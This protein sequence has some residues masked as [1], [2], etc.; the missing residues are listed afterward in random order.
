[1]RLQRPISPDAALRV[2]A[3]EVALFP[4]LRPASPRTDVD[5]FRFSVVV[6]GPQPAVLGL[7][8]G[9]FVAQSL[10]AHLLDVD[11]DAVSEADCANASHEALDRV[12]RRFLARIGAEATVVRSPTRGGLPM[13]DLAAFDTVGGQVVLWYN[14]LGAR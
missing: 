12:A 5:P 1:M 4:P 6:G 13:G 7:Q 8:I 11:E 10:A 2:A 3:T 9:H 14:P